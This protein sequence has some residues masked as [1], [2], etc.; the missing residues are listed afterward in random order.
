MY[1]QTSLLL[2]RQNIV[3][4]KIVDMFECARMT[5]HPVISMGDLNHNYILDET[6]STNPIQYIETVYDTS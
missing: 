5:E 2:S 6:Y 4:K 1:L 3:K